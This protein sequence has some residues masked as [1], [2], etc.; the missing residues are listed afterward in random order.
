MFFAL[1]IFS[2]AISH[3]FRIFASYTPIVSFSLYLIFFSSFFANF[4]TNVCRDFDISP[5][6]ERKRDLPFSLAQISVAFFFFFFF[7]LRNLVLGRGRGKATRGR[8][9]KCLYSV[10]FF[11]RLLTRKCTSTFAL[12]FFY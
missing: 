5:T 12:F 2:L 3:P 1:S 7:Q 6:R 8:K 9:F 11:Y 10:D 4:S